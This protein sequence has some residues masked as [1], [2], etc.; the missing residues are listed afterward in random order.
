MER[1]VYDQMAE[2]QDGH[3]W[4][5][6]RRRILSDMIARTIRLPTQPR[7][8]EAGCGTGGNLQMLARF[9]RVAGF[10]PDQGAV[11]YASRKGDFDIREGSLPGEIPFADDSFDLIAALDVIEHVD[12]DEAS[13]SALAGRLRP[14]GWVLITVPAYPFLWSGHDVNHHHKRRYVKGQLVALACEV[15]LRPVFTSYY[16]SLLFPL[17]ALARLFHKSLR[18]DGVDD[19]GAT[20]KSLNGL[21]QAIFASERHLVGRLPLPAG[22]SLLMLAQKPDCE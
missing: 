1:R 3:W 14:G 10:D 2:L 16:N 12:D 4:F 18:S 7:I 5:V 15:G 21:F 13:L 11:A 8:L 17:I 6:A 22:V 9:G 19:V 20:P